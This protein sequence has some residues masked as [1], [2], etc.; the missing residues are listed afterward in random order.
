M[1]VAR[2]SQPQGTETKCV[3]RQRLPPSLKDPLLPH[4]PTKHKENHLLSRTHL[5]LLVCLILAFLPNLY[6]YFYTHACT[7]GFP[8]MLLSLSLVDVNYAAR[9]IGLGLGQGKGGGG[10]YM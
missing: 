10:S 1:A 8:G 4:H 2:S 3:V 9:M 6:L 7:W 5:L